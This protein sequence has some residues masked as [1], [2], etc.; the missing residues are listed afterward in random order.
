MFSLSNK[1]TI[2]LILTLQQTLV[3]STSLISNKHLSRSENM[4]MFSHGNLTTG[5]KILWKRGE[6]VKEQFLLVSTMF[7]IYT[8]V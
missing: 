5:N 3:I 2:Y 4:S 7:S 1:K 6:I 8:G